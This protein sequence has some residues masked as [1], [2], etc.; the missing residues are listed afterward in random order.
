VQ[1]Q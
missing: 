1:H